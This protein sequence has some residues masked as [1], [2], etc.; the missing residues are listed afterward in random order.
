MEID[1]SFA[2]SFLVL[3][4]NPLG[5]NKITIEP[6]LEDIKVVDGFGNLI[7]HIKF[8]AKTKTTEI[9]LNGHKD[10]VYYVIINN[11]TSYRQQL[12]VVKQGG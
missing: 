2:I 5:V 8:D 10:G 7:M 1:S 11:G 4:G 12:S 6:Q 3:D 9:C